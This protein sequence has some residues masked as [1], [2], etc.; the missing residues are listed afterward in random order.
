MCSILPLFE[1]FSLKR[2]PLK[3]LT[4]HTNKRTNKLL[5]FFRLILLIKERERE[6][7]TLQHFFTLT[8]AQT[9]SS[10]TTTKR[11]WFG[12]IFS[13]FQYT[14]N[15]YQISSWAEKTCTKTWR[16]PSA[17]RKSSK[18]AI[19]PRTTV[20]CCLLNICCVGVVLRVVVGRVGKFGFVC[21]SSRW[22][23]TFE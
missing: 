12:E 3:L 7:K 16:I 8:K 1:V 13:R 2:N 15:R 19:C 9:I 20:R 6:N 17:I 14:Y 11:R 23:K 5:S 18:R 10:S 22:E 21:S 4:I